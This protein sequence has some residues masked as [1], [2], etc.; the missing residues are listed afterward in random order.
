MPHLVTVARGLPPAERDD[1]LYV[2]GLVAMCSGGRGETPADLP[3]D[4]ADA[5]RHALPEAL[6]LLA[7]TLA[8]AE[9]DQITT[10]YLLAATA[11]LKGHPGYAEMLNEL[12]VFAECQ[13]CGEPM[14]EVPE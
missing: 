11:A 14:L 7:E 5:Y 6:T 13:S 3:D 1:Y 10:G 8:T 9:H 2:V 4:I 12:D